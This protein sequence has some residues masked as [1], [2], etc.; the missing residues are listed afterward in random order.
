MIETPVTQH[1][2]GAAAASL[3]LEISGHGHGEV[4]HVA[5]TGARLTV[6]RAYDNDIIVADPYVAAHEMTLTH[7]G[8][9][10]GWTVADSG[11]ENGVMLNGAR[12]STRA[13]N[14]KD[15]DA[16]TI[17]RTSVHVYDRAHAVAPT[18]KTMA[19]SRLFFWASNAAVTWILFILATAALSLFAVAEVWSD[20]P[21][22]IA[23][24]GGGMAAIAAIIWAGHWSLVGKLVVHRTRFREQ[25]GIAS[26]YL[27][28]STA[29]TYVTYYVDYMTSGSLAAVVLNYA[30]NGGML[31]LLIYG[32]L[33]Y[34]T[35]MSRRKRFGSAFFFT[36]GLLGS[37]YALGYIG[38]QDF[39]ENPPYFSA[40][41]PYLSDIAPAKS[42]DGFMQDNTDIFD[43]DIF[44]RTAD[45]AAVVKEVPVVKGDSQQPAP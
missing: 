44:K 43:S 23:A 10:G 24:T 22:L 13:Q 36:A 9:N 5:L 31:V 40:L 4:R 1:V 27:L 35:D 30:I 39:D 6:G 33:G 21:G 28:L 17:G 37:I 18:L 2:S 42:I 8:Q 14:L 38:A 11:S 7:D 45:T 15:G 41:E 32:T 20:Q 19:K 25:M 12:L 29:L 34:A 26:A 3:V 16:L